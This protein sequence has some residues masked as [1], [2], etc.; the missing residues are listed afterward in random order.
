[1]LGRIPL[2]AAP[3]T[4]RFSVTPTAVRAAA[5]A[6]VFAFKPLV[7]RVRPCFC[8]PGIRPLGQHPTDYSFPSGHTAGSFAFAAFVTAWVYVH[9][10]PYGW[11]MSAGVLLFAA[12]VGVSRIYLGVHFPSDVLGAAPHGIVLGVTSARVRSSAPR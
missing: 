3:R 12:A 8:V 10:P 7:G 4:R 1:M 11:L 9:R 2:M 5:A 6:V